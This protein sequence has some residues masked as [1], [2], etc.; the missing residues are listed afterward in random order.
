MAESEPRGTVLLVESDAAERD[1]LASFL[2]D[3]GFELT[4]CPGPSG[5]DY[6]C[7]GARTLECPLAAGVSVVILDTALE[8][9]ELMEGT[10]AEELLGVYLFG[11]HR[12]IALGS[13]L[14]DQVPGQ[15]IRLRRRPEPDELLAAVGSLADRGQVDRW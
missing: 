1:R 11:G 6:T 2:E 7:V 14:H 9:E 3:S 10:A 12:V 4:I 15:M 5:P 8:S 13:Q